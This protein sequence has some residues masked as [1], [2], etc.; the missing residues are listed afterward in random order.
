MNLKIHIN[1][2]YILTFAI[3]W[4]YTLNA[5]ALF[6]FS[7]P[8]FVF[9]TAIILIIL[10]ITLNLS[11][12]P[13]FKTTILV[14]RKDIISFSLFFS[15]MTILSLSNLL[16]DLSGDQIIH[17]I[18]SQ[19]HFIFFLENI[20][21][22]LSIIQDIPF[23][24][25]LYFLN[26]LSLFGLYLI[27]KIPKI[28]R[29]VFN[30]WGLSFLTILFRSLFFMIKTEAIHPP[31]RLFPIW[32]SSS[33]FGPFTFS[34][35]F[36]QLFGLIIFMWFFHRLLSTSFSYWS[37]ILITLCV[38]TIPL[39]WHSAVIVEPTIWISL[40]FTYLL[41]DLFLIE[42]KSPRSFIG[43]F[44]LVSIF[45]LLRAPS[46]FGIIPLIFVF[47]K[48]TKN[49][50]FKKHS[51]P[52]MAL[53]PCLPIFV[54]AIFRKTYAPIADDLG[55]LEKIL[56][57]LNSVTTGNGP[58]IIFNDIG[59]WGLIGLFGCLLI[60]KKKQLFDRVVA[61]LFLISLYTIYFSITSSLWDSTRY[62]IEYAIPFVIFGYGCILFYLRSISKTKRLPFFLLGI[63]ILNISHYYKFPYVIES[64]DIC[65]H[66]PQ[67]GT[68][69]LPQMTYSYNS[70]FEEI[71][72]YPDL[73]EG[74]YL[75][76]NTHGTLLH[77]LNGYTVKE[78]LIIKDIILKIQS[79]KSTSEIANDKLF[80]SIINNSTEIKLL[81]ISNLP[82]EP[83]R[84]NLLK[85]GWNDWK[86]FKNAT[87]KSTIHTLS[88]N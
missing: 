7:L 75:H 31:L 6:P 80:A 77:I 51:L 68:Y 83:L 10:F 66:K 87:Y 64:V 39:L 33:I 17:S 85:L 11:N 29:I 28:K 53:L 73:K 61:L 82:E 88:R 76:G 48:T 1:W 21:R 67:K 18:E 37:S 84:S 86:S 79:Y 57:V 8:L 43:Y 14:Q 12:I 70:L 49:L 59:W 46:L 34:F 9:M 32:L 47:S 44:S 74:L 56:K 27:I 50:N 5:G 42:K 20:G 41:V 15:I 19:H 62:T 81:A 2:S 71:K 26:I 40:F 23:K 16:T 36:P 78:E 45:T 69:K 3:I 30:I 54:Y 35:R 22:R 63:L 13:G 65:V 60:W 72:K 4:C 58:S 55:F 25:L 38:G 24:Y 52:F